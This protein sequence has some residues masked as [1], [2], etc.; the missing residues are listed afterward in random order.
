MNLFAFRTAVATLVAAALAIAPAQAQNR[1]HNLNVDFG[2]NVATCADLHVK[3]DGAL[4]QATD[5]FTMQAAF[6]QIDGGSGG[7][8]HVVAGGSR[9]LRRGSLPVCRG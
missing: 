3:T 9:G 7:A 4:A 2:N 5:K 6:L 8:I 1:H